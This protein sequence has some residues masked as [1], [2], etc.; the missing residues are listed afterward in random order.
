M[1]LQEPLWIQRWTIQPLE[2]LV[3]LRERHR[4]LVEESR[5][6]FQSAPAAYKWLAGELASRNQAF[7]GQLPW[8]AYC[9][10]PDL[11]LQRH[12]L[13][14]GQSQSQ[15]WVLLEMRLPSTDV[16]TFPV[17]AWNIVYC[18]GYLALD[19]L[20]DQQFCEETDSKTVE[21]SWQRLFDP[22]L[23]AQVPWCG[24]FANSSAQVSVVP[25]LHL[26]QLRRVTHF[27]TQPRPIR[28]PNRSGA[29]ED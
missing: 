16:L 12:S 8:W 13:G 2:V 24:L 14:L 7:K 19:E 3:A 22:Q 27:R 5:L 29:I 4:L 11:R 9:R 25:S 17:W 18:R 15:E 6:R 21:R 10:R 1:S 23:P 26:N 20:E 28:L